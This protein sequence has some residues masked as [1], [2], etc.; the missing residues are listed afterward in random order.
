MQAP[1][2][3]RPCRVVAIVS[4][5]PDS[6]CYLARLLSIGCDAHVLSFNYG[7]K[8]SREL[9]VAKNI[10]QKLSQIAVEKGWVGEFLSIGSLIYLL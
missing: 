6:L 5:G 4:G 10:V 9:D 3:V 7:Q 8:G 2:I 1:Y